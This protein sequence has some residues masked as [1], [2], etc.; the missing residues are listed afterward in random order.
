MP[1]ILDSEGRT[2]DAAGKAIQLTSVQTTLKVLQQKNR[3][4][5]VLY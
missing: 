3:V 1:L 5:P 2:I 4:I